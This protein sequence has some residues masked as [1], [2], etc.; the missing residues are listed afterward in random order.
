MNMRRTPSRRSFR[1]A[2]EVANLKLGL[3]SVRTMTSDWAS[4]RPS[5]SILS[6]ERRPLAMSVSPRR[7]FSL[8]D[9]AS[10]IAFASNVSPCTTVASFE[11]SA[12]PSFTWLFPSLYRSTS[13]ATNFRTTSNPFAVHDPEESTTSTTSSFVSHTGSGGQGLGLQ[14]RR[15]YRR[16]WR[17]LG[18]LPD[19]RAG[20]RTRRTLRWVPPP[21]AR[22]QAFQEDH[23]ESLQSASQ[24][25]T[26]HCWVSVWAGHAFP[27]WFGLLLILRTRACSPPPHSLVHRPHLDHEAIW[28]S[29]GHGNSLHFF[30]ICSGGHLMPRVGSWE[31]ARVRSC[32]PPTQLAL[33]SWGRQSVTTQ[34]KIFSGFMDPW[35]NLASSPRTLR[36]PHRFIMN[37]PTR[38]L[39]LV[40]TAL[41]S[42]F[43]ARC[44]RSLFV[45]VCVAS[46]CSAV[47]SP[48]SVL[49]SWRRAFQRAIS[50]LMLD[51]V[52]RH[53]CFSAASSAY[54]AS[55]LSLTSP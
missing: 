46:D 40:S 17:A 32:L 44:S 49:R 48:S 52:V 3:P 42:L 28:Q 41:K 24:E 30:T 39:H 5:R 10:L 13:P 47:A 14:A 35:E 9:T 37:S 54:L 15:L 12:I 38:V 22:L 53:R 45:W 25:A 26:L 7:N 21:Q 1:A 20:A 16:G 2:L 23:L 19:P 11:N 4:L 50:W 8:L 55:Y 6:A 29:I 18:H 51:S 36:R 33:H 43:S 34:S 31:T 27:P